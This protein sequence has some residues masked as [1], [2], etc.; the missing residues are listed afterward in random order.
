MRGVQ[1]P[2]S[3]VRVD[4]MENEQRQPLV[5]AASR[6]ADKVAANLV[7]TVWAAVEEAKESGDEDHDGAVQLLDALRRRLAKS[8]PT[9]FKVHV[10]KRPSLKRQRDAVEIDASLAKPR[11]WQPSRPS[12]AKEIATVVMEGKR[13]TEVPSEKRDSCLLPFKLF[14]RDVVA[15]VASRETAAG[16]TNRS[17]QYAVAEVIY[18]IV[19][20]AEALRQASDGRAATGVFELHGSTDAAWVGRPARGSGIAMDEAGKEIVLAAAAR[21]VERL[22]QPALKLAKLPR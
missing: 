1:T 17:V 19:T 8:H 10:V 20:E 3:D 22:S 11:A 13:V 16:F 6:E 7:A 21:L 9:L 14:G 5:A 12:F 4:M 15:E 18:A 2:Y